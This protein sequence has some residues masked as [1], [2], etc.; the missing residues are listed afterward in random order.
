MKDDRHQNEPY[1]R[2][3]EPEYEQDE[4]GKEYPRI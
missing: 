3:D 4:S 2:R 1:D